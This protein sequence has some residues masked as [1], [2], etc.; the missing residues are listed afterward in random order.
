MVYNDANKLYAE[1]KASG[2]SLIDEALSVIFPDSLPLH[3]LESTKKKYFKSPYN[4]IIGYNT[5]FLPRWDIIKIS[6]NGA[7]SALKAQVLQ[8]SDDGKEGYAVMQTPEGSQVGQ[9][10]D[11][12]STLHAQLWPASGMSSAMRV[13]L[14]HF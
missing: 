6:L 14:N 7:N 5:T 9:L 12:S 4:K 8:A 13:C 11:S 1:V 3:L 10:R 2:E